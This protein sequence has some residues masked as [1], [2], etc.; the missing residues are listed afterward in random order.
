MAGMELPEISMMNN[1]MTAIEMIMMLALIFAALPF[2]AME[3]SELE[4]NNVMTAILQIMMIVPMNVVLPFA[5]MEL[6]ELEQNNVMIGILLL[7]YVLMVNDRVLSVIIN[8]NLLLAQRRI[9][10][11]ELY[12]RVNSAMMEM[13]FL[14]MDVQQRAA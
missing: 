8:V 4:Q 9:V 10:V 3:L 7:K 11:T 6:P 13:Q 2:A 1:V 14:V 12:K 5:V